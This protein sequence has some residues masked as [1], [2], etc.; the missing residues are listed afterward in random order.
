MARFAPSNP[1][2]LV[3][4]VRA[5][6]SNA[7]AL[8]IVTGGS[9]RALG[10][11]VRAAHMVDITALSGIVSYEPEELVV[12]VQAGTPLQHLE[13]VLA[14]RNQCLACEPPELGALLGNPAVR[15]SIGGVV[16]TGLSGPR[17]FKAGAVRDHV[18]GCVA[19]SGRGERFVSGGKVVKNVTGYDLPKLLTGSY[20]TLAVLTEITLKVLPRAPVERTLLVAG[21][22]L[23][24]AVR[25]MIDVL[26][27]PAEISGACHLPAGLELPHVPLPS[28]V[29]GAPITALRFEGVAPS[30]E[31]RL[32]RVRE[33]VTSAGTLAVIEQTQSHAFWQAVRDVWP[34]VEPQGSMRIVWRLSVPPAGSAAVIER[35]RSSIPEAQYFLDWGGGLIWLRLP[36]DRDAR[37]AEVRGA[38]GNAGGHATLIRAPEE[39]RARTDVFMPQSAPLAALSRRVKTQFDPAGVLNPGR[40]FPD[41]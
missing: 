11:P 37:A 3:D 8:E 7:E 29:G 38:L 5:A 28:A 1:G 31:F 27:T 17:R 33:Q 4:V 22:E 16:A 19:V 24:A 25:L 13:A 30:V 36:D 18:L 26:Q 9:K 35:V 10:R 23:Q 21:P 20:G 14:E 15:A 40:M 12:T 41:A 32:S 39:I 6:A 2:E 34:F